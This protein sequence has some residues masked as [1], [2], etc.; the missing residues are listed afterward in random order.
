MNLLLKLRLI[1]VLVYET[2]ADLNLPLCTPSLTFISSCFWDPLVCCSCH[3]ISYWMDSPAEFYVHLS[4]VLFLSQVLYNQSVY[5]EYMEFCS[6]GSNKSFVGAPTLCS[7]SCLILTSL[8]AADVE[9]L[10][11]EREVLHEKQ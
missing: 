7:S 5:I 8:S 4:R 3:V 1:H 9:N 6:S 2:L 10:D 11:F